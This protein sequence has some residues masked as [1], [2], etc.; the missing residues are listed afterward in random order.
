MQISLNPAN[1]PDFI[2]N[3]GLYKNFDFT[4]QEDEFNIPS[5][6]FKSDTSVNSIED[7]EILLHVIRFWLLEDIPDEIYSFV[8]NNKE[9]DYGNI[10]NEFG[11]MKVIS[12]LKIIIYDEHICYVAVEKG[13]LNLYKYLSRLDYKF[14]INHVIYAVKF[15]QYEIF[16]YLLENEYVIKTWEFHFDWNSEDKDIFKFICKS[17][18]SRFLKYILDNRKLLL[19]FVLFKSSKFVKEL[20]TYSAVY[21]KLENLKVLREHGFK[22]DLNSVNVIAQKGFLDCLKFAHNDGCPCDSSTT[23]SAAFN[24]NPSCLKYLH[25]NGCTWDV[26]TTYSAARFNN[27]EVLKYAHENGCPWNEKTAKLAASKGS[28]ECLKYA[29]ENGCPIDES[30]LT[31]SLEKLRVDCFKFGIEN[32]F[33]QSFFDI[34]DLLDEPFYKHCFPLV[35]YLIENNFEYNSDSL[36]YCC[37]GAKN[38]N[39]FEF[40]DYA[41]EKCEKSSA[42]T[43]RAAL[44]GDLKFLKFCVE[45]GAKLDEE[46]LSCAA[47]SDNLELFKYVLENNCPVDVQTCRNAACADDLEILEYAHKNGCPWNEESVEIAAL[48]GNLRCLKYLLDNNCP[49]GNATSHAVENG[50]YGCLVLLHEYNVEWDTD[51]IEDCIKH[52]NCIDCLKYAVDNG[53]PCDDGMIELAALYGRLEEMKYLISKGFKLEKD[54]SE[55]LIQNFH[56]FTKV[57]A[58]CLKFVIEKGCIPVEFPQ[59]QDDDSE[60]ISDD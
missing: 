7:L 31:S 44:D 56:E 18:D 37:Y 53:A 22:C 43:S 8:L 49:T 55:T 10:F 23:G 54:L 26:S 5:K 21:G 46:T 9:L 2:K 36:W 59:I 17:N 16:V 4:N 35:K 58:K 3:S 19:D 6:Y 34:H 42:I 29:F 60:E 48:E 50:N 13:C 38:M 45:H 20:L 39:K 57:H 30:V 33:P 52:S 14:E 12:E 40:F 51:T 24:K 27:L 41:I 25:E 11:N 15:N 1:T 32:N 47:Y 28:L